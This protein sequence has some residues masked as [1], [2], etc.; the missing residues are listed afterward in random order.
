VFVVPFCLCLSNCC[1]GCGAIE[2]EEE[3]SQSKT[4][5][6]P[7]KIA[8]TEGKLS[9]NNLAGGFGRRNFSCPCPKCERLVVGQIN[10]KKVCPRSHLS[11]LGIDKIPKT[12]EHNINKL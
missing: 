8:T 6:T 12:H 3:G 7:G 11:C 5:K 4:S 9:P 1:Q 2:N 10:Q